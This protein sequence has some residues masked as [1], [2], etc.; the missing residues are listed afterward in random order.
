L[1]DT[2]IDVKA[3]MGLTRALRF[4][5]CFQQLDNM[6]ARPDK[7]IGASFVQEIVA[8][9]KPRR[10]KP[11]NFGCRG[12]GILLLILLEQRAAQQSQE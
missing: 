10:K 8:E 4:F 1:S 6:T 11:R 5:L 2:G 12:W 7:W 3:V 9:E